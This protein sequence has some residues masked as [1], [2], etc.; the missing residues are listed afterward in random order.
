MTKGEIRLVYP[1]IREGRVV[2]DAV[3]GGLGNY[4]VGE[5]VSVLIAMGTRPAILVPRKYVT[6][7]FGV[8]YARLV[9]ADN[10]ISETPIQTTAGPSAD[11]AEVLSGLRAGDVLSPAGTAK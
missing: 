5:R 11:T 7:R 10:T 1:E 6:T 3:V 9:R 2:A 4:F 8:D